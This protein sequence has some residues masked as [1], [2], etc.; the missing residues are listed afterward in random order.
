MEKHSLNKIRDTYWNTTN[1]EG[2]P[3]VRMV[4]T[5]KD[6]MNLYFLTQMF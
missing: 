5:F 3:S 1:D 4:A 6:D 2:M